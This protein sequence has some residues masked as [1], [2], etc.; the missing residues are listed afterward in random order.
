M[1]SRSTICQGTSIALLLSVWS[2]TL[3]QPEKWADPPYMQLSKNFTAK[4]KALPTIGTV[5]WKLQRI[6][7]ISNSPR[8]GISG[9]GM[10]ATG[11]KIY[12]MGGFIPAG[13]GSSNRASRRTSRWTYSYDPQTNRW[14]RL[15]DM[16]ARREYTRAIAT[17]KAVYVIGGEIL[18][19]LV[20]WE[21]SLG[22]F[23]HD[24]VDEFLAL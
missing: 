22:G 15:P 8:A 16:P 1:N 11:G 5:D 6:P 14:T 20:F 18:S 17:N 7:F 12:L 21:F 9:A 24:S 23:L 19:S 10:V 4:V 2:V 3:A 13:D